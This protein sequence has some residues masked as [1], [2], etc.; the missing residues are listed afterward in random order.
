MAA[1]KPLKLKILC[2][3]AGIAA[4]FAALAVFSSERALSESAKTSVRPENSGQTPVKNP[5]LQA[6]NEHCQPVTMTTPVF[7]D[8]PLQSS[9][10]LAALFDVLMAMQDGADEPGYDRLAHCYLS[11][12]P[13]RFAEF[14]D[15]FG[16]REHDRKNER[17]ENEQDNPAG[18]THFGPLYDHSHDHIRL[19][20]QSLQTCSQALVY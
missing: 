11:R 6:A 17:Q 9:Y 18:A 4:V 3:A 20:F 13:S 14:V 2:K 10:R 12:F 1:I 15:V 8:S 19:F 7:S 5:G 16:Y